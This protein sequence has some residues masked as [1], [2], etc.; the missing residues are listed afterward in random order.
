[1]EEEETL[2]APPPYLKNFLDNSFDKGLVFS[3]PGIC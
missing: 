2:S 1:M 3:L